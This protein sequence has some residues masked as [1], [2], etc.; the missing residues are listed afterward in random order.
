[1]PFMCR[2]GTVDQPQDPMPLVIFA[3]PAGRW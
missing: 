3:K 1:M 2:C